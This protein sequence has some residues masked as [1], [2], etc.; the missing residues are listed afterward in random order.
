MLFLS[1]WCCLLRFFFLSDPY[2]YQMAFENV[3]HVTTKSKIILLII[4][5]MR[6][7]VSG[8]F[9][10]ILIHILDATY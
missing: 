2:F 8:L 6:T 7:P 1:V 5:V 4:H 9:M 3:L 10:K